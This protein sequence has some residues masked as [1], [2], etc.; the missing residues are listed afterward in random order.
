MKKKIT[1]QKSS[2]RPF[3]TEC[4]NELNRKYGGIALI[5]SLSLPLRVT[6]H[7]RREISYHNSDAVSQTTPT[8]D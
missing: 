5:L 8:S 7:E 6:G 1:L 4:T 2:S 3:N